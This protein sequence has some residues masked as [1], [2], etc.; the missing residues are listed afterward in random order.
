M[1]CS[2]CSNAIDVFALQFEARVRRA[3]VV[4]PASRSLMER[5]LAETWMSEA[6]TSVRSFTLWK[7]IWSERGFLFQWVEMFGASDSNRPLPKIEDE[8]LS[9]TSPVGDREE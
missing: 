4:F 5:L 8:G 2:R 6:G 7:K 1:V 3:G 9:Q